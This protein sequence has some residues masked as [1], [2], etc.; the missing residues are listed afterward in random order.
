M[1][2]PQLLFE[3]TIK[4]A[5][6]MSKLGELLAAQLIPGDLV[7]LIGALGAGKTTF[8]CVNRVG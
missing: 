5:A 2:N 6:E 3:A 1:S 4:S 8:D 7:V